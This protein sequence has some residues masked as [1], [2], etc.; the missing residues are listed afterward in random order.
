MHDRR[1]FADATSVRCLRIP[2]GRATT[3]RWILMLTGNDAFSGSVVDHALGR[4]A[5]V[6]SARHRNA[7]HNTARLGVGLRSACHS[8]QG[9]RARILLLQ[10]ILL[11]KRCR[12]RQLLDRIFAQVA[13]LYG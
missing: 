12:A 5:H 8:A 11:A 9:C 6:D 10:D 2:V 7:L 3:I 1:R 4:D 13:A